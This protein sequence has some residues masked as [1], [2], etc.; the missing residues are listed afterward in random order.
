MIARLRRIDRSIVA[1]SLLLATLVGMLSGLVCVAFRFG[2]RILQWLITGQ[3]GLLAQAA[4]HMPLWRRAVT[5]I[6]GAVLATLVAKS[7]ARHAGSKG[8]LDYVEAVQSKGGW[9]PFAPAAWKAIASGFSISSGAAIGREGSMIQ[10]AASSVSLFGQRVA[11]RALSP[12]RLV[13]CGAAAAAAAV[14]RAPIAGAFF[15]LEIVLGMQV[16][17]WTALTELPVLLVASVA[18]A[19]LSSLFEGST[20]LFKAVVSTSLDLQE[21]FRAII[22]AAV[23][24]LAGPLYL[25]ITKGAND[26]KQVPLAVVWSGAT[27]GLLS[28]LQ[29][30]VWGNGDSA[31]LETLG[32]KLTIGLAGAI[33]L[34]RLCATTACVGAGVVGGVFTPTVFAGSVLGLLC[35]HALHPSFASQSATPLYSVL[36]IGCLLAS[37]THAP[38]MAAAMAAELTG[39]ARMLPLT[40]PC[41]LLSWQVASMLSTQ[42]LYRVATPDP[43]TSH[44]D[45]AQK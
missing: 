33:L 27:V 28:C 26:F 17:S 22:T 2:L 14:Y 44:E 45:G 38:F 23:A 39:T 30:E 1:R 29:P 35:G 4:V 13:A 42:S 6:I 37:V 12:Q 32:G 3:G 21:V 24:G 25:W 34:L 40:L 18:G 5:P 9:V 36:G 15:G 20:P 43:G 16:L 31:I 11:V 8:F 19:L 41:C 7:A 10:F